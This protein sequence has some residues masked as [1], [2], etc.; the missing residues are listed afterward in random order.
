[1]TSILPKRISKPSA[2]MTAKSKFRL[3]VIRNRNKC[4]EE[5]VRGVE[6]PENLNMIRLLNR[7]VICWGGLEMSL[8]NGVPVRVLPQR[9]RRVPGAAYQ[10]TFCRSPMFQTVS[11]LGIRMGGV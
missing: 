7:L 5:N 1:M 3:V 8:K 4:S 11:A 6:I 10:V 2:R 9:N